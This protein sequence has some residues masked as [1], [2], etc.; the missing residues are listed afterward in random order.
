MPYAAPLSA[1]Y[2]QYRCSRSSNHSLTPFDCVHYS[3]SS[4]S[5]GGA[6][7]VRTHHGEFVL[8]Q[9]Q[10]EALASLRHLRSEALPKQQFLR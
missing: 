1:Y 6:S 8:L 4:T 5:A 7:A 9:V 2:V 10:L 3:G